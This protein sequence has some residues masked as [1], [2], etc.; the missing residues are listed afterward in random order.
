MTDAASLLERESDRESAAVDADVLRRDVHHAL[1]RGG[2]D[3]PTRP[4]TSKLT[5]DQADLAV[6]LL[7]GFSSR[8]ELI[9][10][11]QDLV[12]QSLGQLTDEWYTRVATDAPTV[13]ALL[14]AP[15]GPLEEFDDDVA[16][17]IRRG[18]VAKDLLP[19]FHAAHR[20]F[21]W[22]AVERVDHLDD[23]GDGDDVDPIDPERQEFPAMRPAFGELHGQQREA[24]ESLLGGFESEDALLLWTVQVVGSSYSEIDAE[25]VEATYFETELR[26]R[27]LNPTDGRLDRFVRESWAAEYLLPAFNRAAAE[28][29]DR[30]A[31][32]TARETATGDT[33]AGSIS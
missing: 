5:H 23:D 27:L 24:L 29:A 32:V 3:V 19:A 7:A 31:E 18:I 21:R 26:E 15:W 33:G 6:D 25:T 1:E 14:G 4:A 10:W 2:V 8:R 20:E 30:A 28:I 9:E 16:H 22:A 12:I 11:Q 13:S 17:E